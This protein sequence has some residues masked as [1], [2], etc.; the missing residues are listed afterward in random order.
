M[1]TFVMYLILSIVPISVLL[2]QRRHLIA[3]MVMVTSVG[4]H[5]KPQSVQA[6]NIQAKTI[7]VIRGFVMVNQLLEKTNNGFFERPIEFNDD[8]VDSLSP[9]QRIEIENIFDGFD[10]WEMGSFQQMS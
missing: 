8:L 10:E 6:V 5:R 7:K 3:E 1:I 2:M 9:V 4:I